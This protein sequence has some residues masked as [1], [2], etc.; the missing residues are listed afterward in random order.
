MLRDF[1][2]FQRPLAR[3]SCPGAAY[4]L[5]LDIAMSVVRTSLLLA[6]YTSLI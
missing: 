1:C 6:H 3:C 5:S 2:T 4:D